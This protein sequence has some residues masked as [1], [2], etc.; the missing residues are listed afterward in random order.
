[1]SVG[2]GA[3]AA[4]GRAHTTR[5]SADLTTVRLGTN[6]NLLTLPVFVADR[7]GYFKKHGIKIQYVTVVNPAP[8]LISGDIDVDA[9]A[10][11]TAIQLAAQGK[12]APAIVALQ[13]RNS[14]VFVGRS[15]ESWPHA[16]AGYPSVMHDLPK[17]AVIGVSVRAG[18][19][20]A[21]LNGLFT[22]S[23]GLREGSDYTIVVL[24]TPQAVI[25]ALKAKRIDA[26]VLF[27]PWDGQAYNMK[28]AV[29]LVQ[30]AQGQPPGV[31]AGYGTALLA[32]PG[33]LAAHP[34]VAKNVVAAIVQGEAYLRNYKKHKALL[35]QI[36]ERYA[37]VT[38]PRLV[39]A[40]LPEAAALAHPQFT[41]D[42]LTEQI[43]EDY[44]VK[45]ITSMPTCDQ[46]ADFGL[47]PKKG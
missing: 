3:Q 38:D 22:S 19:I 2:A 18:G 12:S 34:A 43:L 45:T 25:D 41:C 17:G 39:D 42:R 36:G 13:Q 7:L 10:T 47:A 1:M 33:F 20:A 5:A 32:S 8:P 4:T 30:E 28:V 24:G 44:A 31:G 23:L 40:F 15:D 14:L 9:T 35:E 26:G 21:F 37:G 27:A 16:K 29:P 6:P 11:D 46:V